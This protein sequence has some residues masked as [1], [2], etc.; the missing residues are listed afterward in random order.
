MKLAN[1]ETPRLDTEFL[2]PT[3]GQTLSKTHIAKKIGSG[4][5]FQRILYVKQERTAR[6][7]EHRT[8][9]KTLIFHGLK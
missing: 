5:L 1:Q 8:G 3:P 9:Y 2:S 4:A 7:F 6:Y